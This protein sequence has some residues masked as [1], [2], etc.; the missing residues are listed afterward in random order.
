M[1]LE[2][3]VIGHL[4][5]VEHEATDMLLN[6]QRQADEKVAEAR[7]KCDREF[8]AKNS[9]MLAQLEADEKSS[10]EKI[11]S[12]YGEKISQFKSQLESSARDKNA[13][14]LLLEKELFA[15]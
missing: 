9:S 4:L 2:S 15:R 8:L 13:F 12:V 14:N 7:M 11:A 1:A 5:E 3:D 10:K 6:A